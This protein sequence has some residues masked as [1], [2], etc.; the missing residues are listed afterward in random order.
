L[1]RLQLTFVGHRGNIRP[2]PNNTGA[3]D[4]DQPAYYDPDYGPYTGHPHDPRYDYEDIDLDIE[5][6]KDDMLRTPLFVTDW[7][8]HEATPTR[9]P[10]TCWP[11]RPSCSR[12]LPT[13]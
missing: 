9:R 7:L 2:S 5:A 3:D 6:A 8:A 12:P 11:C 4:E 13:S 10:S 1:C